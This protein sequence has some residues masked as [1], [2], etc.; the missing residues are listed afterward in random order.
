M[1]LAPLIITHAGGTRPLPSYRLP[2]VL[3][4]YA[5]LPDLHRG[6]GGIVMRGDRGA[7]P[8]PF[9]TEAWIEAS[10]LPAAYALAL[11]IVTECETATSVSTH[12]G[13]VPTDGLLAYHVMIDGIAVRLRL[14]FAP[15]QAGAETLAVWTV[16]TTSVTADQTDGTADTVFQS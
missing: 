10:D 15:T 5:V 14:E 16:D 9:T 12:W 4:R 1:N 13:V 3:Q 2:A 8:A 7:T 11:E 6:S